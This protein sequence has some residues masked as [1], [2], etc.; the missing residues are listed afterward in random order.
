LERLEN[1]N[2]RIFGIFLQL[3][4]LRKLEILDLDLGG[5]KQISK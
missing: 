2:V 1:N 4:E 5:Q 3:S